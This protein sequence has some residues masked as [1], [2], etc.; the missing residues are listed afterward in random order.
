MICI[1]LRILISTVFFI[2]YEMNKFIFSDRNIVLPLWDHGTEISRAARRE[3]NL[4]AMI[5]RLGR[6]LSPW[7]PWFIWLFMADNALER[8]TRSVASLWSSLWN[9]LPSSRSPSFLGLILNHSPASKPFSTFELLA[10]WELL[11]RQCC[12]WWLCC[13]TKKKCS[14]I[15]THMLNNTV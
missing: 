6:H 2:V 9:A 10:L 3:T 4:L 13:Y 14:T 5:L 15:P 1:R 11:K 8:L 12:Q 7:C